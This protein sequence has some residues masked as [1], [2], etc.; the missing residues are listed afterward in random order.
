M[1]ISLNIS[2]F[3]PQLLTA[4]RNLKD[5]IHQYNCKKEIFNLNERHDTT[6]LTTNK[7]F[8]KDV[9]ARSNACYKCGEMGHFQRDCKYNGDKPMDGQQEQEGSFD[10][11][12][13]VVG[14]CMTNLVATTPITS[15]AM[16]SLYAKLNRQIDLKRTYR[17]RYKDLQ[18]VV[19]TTTDTSM[20]V[21]QPV[22]VTSSKATSNPQITKTMPA[23][24]NKK[25]LDKGKA[26][27][28]GK[29]KNYVA[30]ST[31]NVVTTAG[32]SANFQSHLRDKAKLTAVLIQEIMEELQVIEEE[33]SKEEQD[34]E[35]TQESDLEQEDSDNLLTDSEQ[36]LC[37]RQESPSC[38]SESN[39]IDKE[40]DKNEITE[41]K[42]SNIDISH[43]EEVIIGTEQGTTF[44]TKIGTSMCNALIDT[45]ATRSC[46]S[47]KYY[48]NLPS[49]KIHHLRN[50]SVRSATGSN[51]TPLGLINCSFELG[52][53]RF[54]SD[55]IV[56]RNLTRPLIL[57]RDFLIQ[58][59][60]TVWYADDGK[61]ILDYQQHE[62]LASIDVED[63]P[64]H[65]M[66]HSVTL[67]GRSLAIVC[68]YNNLDP[69]QSG[70]IYEIEPSHNLYEKYPNLCVTPMI[71]NVDVH[72]TEMYPW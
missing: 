47:E 33:S 31:P 53:I 29:I 72:K 64:L 24:Q 30:K 15:K 6:D 70:Y 49:T 39:V 20:T 1:N 25:A 34:S 45:G 43:T 2:K 7:N 44:P 13:P 21:L 65:N 11:Y 8:F 22:T 41:M 61:C 14:K 48:Q 32:P 23:G 57:G 63:K 71:H 38:T 3:G 28:L 35:A 9:R 37:K 46:I 10:S 40:F 55:L 27:P 42:M 66:A 69:D 36:W 5:F 18:A 54:N 12:N 26:K 59:H 68:I 16:K 56:C 4:L 19:A 17:L 51:L 58:N 60:I 50:I 67:P 52:R 62:L